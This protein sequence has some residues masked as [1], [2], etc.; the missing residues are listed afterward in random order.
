MKII[1]TAGPSYE[2][3]DRVRRLTNFSTGELGTLL[4]EAFAGAGHKVILFRG[5]SA[6]FPPPLWPVEV[7]PFKTNDDL[8]SSLRRLLKKEEVAIVFQ[9]AALCDYRVKQVVDNA[10]QPVQ[11]GKFPSRI[12]AL[13]L[14]L[15]P[16]PKVIASLRRMFPASLLVGWKYELDG[17]TEEVVAKGRQQMDEYLTDVSVLNGEAYGSGFG[18][19]IRSGQ[20]VHL[21]DKPAL[22]R[23]L[24][25]WAEKVPMAMGTP[26]PES[27]HA[28][29]SFM[30]L[31]PF[32]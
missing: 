5:E 9:A 25:E 11:G 28:L 31:A 17:T 14:T 20:R 16:L 10:G 4:A 1:I 8:E 30:P 6:T 26:R 32:I 19:I 18:V 13:Q 29:A 12:G 22:C 24:L 27:F 3:I 21:P 2:P 7:I 15:E 23:F